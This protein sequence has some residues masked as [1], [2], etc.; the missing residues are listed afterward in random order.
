MASAGCDGDGLGDG[1]G[2]G[3]GE[4]LGAGVAQERAISATRRAVIKELS[5]IFDFILPPYT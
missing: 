1:L 3:E 2:E 5:N 4:G